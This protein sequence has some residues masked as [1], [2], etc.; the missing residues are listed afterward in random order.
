M[1]KYITWI[2]IIF[3][4]SFYSC[5]KA[6][7]QSSTP[8]NTTTSQK[9]ITSVIDIDGNK[10][11]TIAIGTQTWMVENLKTTHYRNGDPIPV[12]ADSAQWNND[13]IGAYCNYDN[14]TGNGNTYGHLY[15]WYAVNNPA[16]ISPTG[17]HIPTDSEWSVL[18]TYLGGDSLA[19]GVMKSTGTTLWNTLN[20]GATNSSGFTG[21]PAGNRL[22]N[23]S[24]YG[25]NNYSHF[26]S[27]TAIND[28]TSWSRYLYYFDSEL[29]RYYS[30]KDVGFSCRCIK[31]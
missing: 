5:K 4:L 13:L 18:A 22:N 2:V 25:I 14:N 1:K 26:W 29:Y 8:E 23:E 31:G 16:G 27:S 10:Y 9:T 19:G 3:T 12:L 17:W 30:G 28:S 6:D 11:D 24:F 20:S 15:N 21:L 7:T